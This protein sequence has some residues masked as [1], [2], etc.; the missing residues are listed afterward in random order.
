M[1]TVIRRTDNSISLAERRRDLLHAVTWQVQVRSSA[2]SPPTDVY[3][4]DAEVVVRLEVAGMRDADFEVTLEDGFLVISGSRP[5]VQERRAYHQ[6]EIRF[7][8]FSV[9][10]ALP[11]PVN[12][13]RSRA[14][15]L[16]GFLT[17]VLPKAKPRNVV[18]KE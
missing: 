5:D 18:I 8:R 14:E 3:E 6:M 12:V 11:G 1:P 9:T 7:G 17:V 2:W 4:T 16:D 13:E 15:Y 10:V